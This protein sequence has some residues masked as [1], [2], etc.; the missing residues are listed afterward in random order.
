MVGSFAT[1]LPVRDPVFHRFLGR[2]PSS[3][4]GSV[5]LAARGL[6]SETSTILV[7]SGAIGHPAQAWGR[8]GGSDLREHETP[9]RPSRGDSHLIPIDL[10]RREKARKR[11]V[12]GLLLAE[13]E[14]FEPSV[15]F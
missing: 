4:D 7:H 5:C 3:L 11:D 6:A 8:S 12:C 13:S 2:G 10:A 9:V 15:S 14:G 1:D